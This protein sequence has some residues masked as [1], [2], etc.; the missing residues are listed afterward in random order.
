MADIKFP[1]DGSTWSTKDQ[2]KADICTKFIGRGS[3]RSSTNR[4]RMAFAEKQL[5]NTSEYNENDIVFVS[6][7]GNRKGRF[8]FDRIKNEVIL[9]LNAKAVIVCDNDYNRNRSYNVGER[10]LYE[11]LIQQ[12]Y[13]EFINNQHYS[14]FR[15]GE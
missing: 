11:F 4:Y 14:A 13:V 2:H 6:V 10:E 12:G 5:A 7:E 3:V 8:S 1:Y 9:A 15:K